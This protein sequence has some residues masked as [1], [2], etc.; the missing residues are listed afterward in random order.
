MGRKELA[1]EHPLERAAD[2]YLDECFSKET[3]PH[4]NELA[5]RLGMTAPQFSR[6]FAR[7]TGLAP[8]AYLKAATI[9]RAEHL[10]RTTD[11]PLNAVGYR[12][13]FGTRTTF[14]RAFRRAKGVTPVAYRR[15]H[16]DA[17]GTANNVTRRK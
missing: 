13:G 7:Q 14:F 8:S 15:G 4:V 10:L 3:A 5:A 9:A 11:L 2:A 17:S 16:E 1:S 6:A 12:S